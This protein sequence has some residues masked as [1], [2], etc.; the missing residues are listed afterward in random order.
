MTLTIA[1]S[2]PVVLQ[3]PPAWTRMG[4]REFAEFCRLNPDLRIERTAKGDIQVMP[5]AGGE[6]GRREFTLTVRFG[7]WAEADG[8]GIGFSPSTGFTLPNGAKRAPDVAWVRRDR[9][10]AL[11]EE[12]REKFPPLCPDFV[13]ELRSRT[14]S[15]EPLQEKMQEYLAHGAQ[16]GWLI[17]RIERKLYVYRAD[18]TVE[19][20]DDPAQLSGEPLLPGFVLHLKEIWG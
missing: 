18:G 6:T 14:D 7:V 20:L 15:L 8:S 16:L 3:L 11:T 9:W 12:E 4:D 1:E 13:V 17:D 5:P 10:E 2:Q 19:C